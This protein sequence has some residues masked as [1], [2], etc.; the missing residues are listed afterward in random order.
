[1]K[2]FRL[3]LAAAVAV[4]VLSAC[5]DDQSYAKL[6]NL[7]NQYVNNYLADQRVEMEIPA[8]SVFE[9]GPDAPYYRLDEDGY[10]YMQVINPGTPGNKVK[11]NE[12]I[13]FRYIRYGLMSYRDGKL[14]D[15]AGN[16]L[17]LSTCWFRFNNFTL[18]GSYQWGSG[19]QW[20]LRFLS[21]DC[22]VNIVIKSQMG[23][24]EEQ[25]SVQPFLYHVTYQR[26]VN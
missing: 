25:T 24:V 19:I 10:L 3:I 5:S 22:E 18:Q 16:S 21:V 12:Q 2:S 20:P 4:F 15:G 6:L 13:Y 26:S 23:I 14:P 17:T 1:M 8:D 9:Y 7:E 11:D